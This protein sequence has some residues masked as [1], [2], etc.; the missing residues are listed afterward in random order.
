MKAVTALVAV[1]GAAPIDKVITMIGEL[2]QKIIGE[3]E[4][5]HKVYV[6]F[7]EWCEDTSKNVMYEIKTGKSDKESLE[8]EIAKEAANIDAQTAKI[9]E[10][11]GAISLDEADLKAATDI[12]SKEEADFQA[13][14]K[15]LVETV[16]TLERAIGII[17]KE[18]KKGGAALAQ[19]QKGSGVIMALKAM[20]DAQSLSTADGSKLSA[21]IQS[22]QKSDDEDEDTG[23][24]AAATYENQSGG[25]LDVLNDLLEKAQGELDKARAQE[26]ANIQ[27]F[28]MLKKSLED[29]IKFANK[30][31]SEAHTSKTGSEEGKATAEGDL[32]VTTKALNEDVK[33]LSGLHHNCLTRAEEYE[34]ET[35][36]R[37]EELGALAKAKE[38]IKEAVGASAASFLQT[39]SQIT[40]QMDL[41]NFEVVRLIRDLAKKENSAALAQLAS[42]VASTV[43]FGGGDQADMFGKVKGMITDM[44]EKLEAE[45]ESDATEKAFCD[46]ELAETRLKKD[47]KTAE[48][49]KLSTSIESMS[50]KSAKLKE[51]VATLQSE[52]SALTKSQ[53]EMDKIRA[54]EKAVFEKA[55]SDTQKAL[56]GVKM[57]LKVLND[58]YSKSDKAHSSSDGAS[59]GII[60]LLE[61]CESDF[62]KALAE[63][64]AEEQ[65]AASA[66]DAE[67][68]ENEIMKVTKEQDVK[69]K[70]KE[71]NGLDKSVAEAS[72]DKAGVETE[73]SAVNEYL[74]KLEGRCIAK[75]ETYAERKERRASEIEGLKNALQILENETALIQQTSRRFLR[76]RRHQM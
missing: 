61:V 24:P 37:D 33:D 75:A 3:G 65:T 31:K 55:S 8:A 4:D 74:A 5:A 67:T 54:E 76:L 30:E 45:A 62:S 52:L 25:I 9:E 15:D 43:R 69:Y 59:T 19:F 40:S 23:A 66:Y 64:T 71:S 12:R 39:F 35:K 27:N 26:T 22:N 51:E 53:A 48:I 13:K 56:D 11:A 57:A 68:K 44:I 41:A 60:G 42:R 50:A 17:E 6:E 10:L 34:A 72:S 46:K 1:A 38:I 58:Y 29:E 70:T 28:E 21:L 47:D 32:D 14:E 73:L 36:S 16:D 7:S 2:E 63:M 49:E 20:V 18:M